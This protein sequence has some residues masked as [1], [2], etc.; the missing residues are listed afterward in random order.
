MY[1]VNQW[2]W[3]HWPVAVG[4]AMCMRSTLCCGSLGAGG[5]AWGACLCLRSRTGARR[6]SGLGRKGVKR[7]AAA[8]RQRGAEMHA[9]Y[10]TRSSV[11]ISQDIS[12]SSSGL[13]KFMILILVYPRLCESRL[14]SHLTSAYPDIS[15][16]IP[17]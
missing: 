14:S 12:G 7:P 11:G 3:P 13:C 6:L 16:D 9:V 4:E 5:H 10:G 1:E 2:L 15:W 17:F 8:A